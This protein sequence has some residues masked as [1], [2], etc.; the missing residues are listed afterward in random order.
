MSSKQAL[1][2]FNL[3]SA[4]SLFATLGEKQQKVAETKACKVSF[5][6]IGLSTIQAE[7]SAFFQDVR[8]DGHTRAEEVIGHFDT[9]D[10]ATVIANTKNS[11]LDS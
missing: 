5:Q 6:G 10:L 2:I 11:R 3:K 7:N 8:Q 9:D 1:A 4:V